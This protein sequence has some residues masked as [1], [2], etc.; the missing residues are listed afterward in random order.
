MTTIYGPLTELGTVAC[1][2]RTPQQ[3]D[4]PAVI[5]RAPDLVTCTH[6]WAH[7]AYAHFTEAFERVH[8]AGVQ[9]ERWP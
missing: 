6:T 4:P 9:V 8:F 2:A 3:L 5:T 7:N 1:C